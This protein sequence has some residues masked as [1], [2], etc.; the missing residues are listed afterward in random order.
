M[1]KMSLIRSGA[2]NCL[3]KRCRNLKEFVKSFFVLLCLTFSCTCNRK[4]SLFHSL[5]SFNVAQAFFSLTFSSSMSSKQAKKK[6][7]YH[8]EIYVF[9]SICRLLFTCTFKLRIS[10]SVTN[11][12][13]LKCAYECSVY[14]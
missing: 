5:P 11:S 7:N 6:K 8:S 12:V 9:L 4:L 3:Q 1:K 2:H 13:P 14:L 10:S